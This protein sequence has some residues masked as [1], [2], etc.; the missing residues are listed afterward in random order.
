MK[1]LILML[2]L[3]LAGIGVCW[4]GAAASFGQSLPNLTG[5]WNFAQFATPSRLT[6]MTANT[7]VFGTN[8][9]TLRNIQ[10]KTNFTARLTPMTI[11]GSGNFSG[12]GTGIITVAGPGLVQAVP[13]GESGVMFSVNAAQDVA[14]AAHVTSDSGEQELML[15]LK[16]PA[17]LTTADL[18]GVWKMVTLGT[19]QN[20]GLRWTTNYLDPQH[21]MDGVFEVDGRSSFDAGAGTLTV[22]ADGSFSLV[23]GPQ[24]M[25]GTATPGASGLV[26]VTIPMP[27]PSP[28]LVIPFY[29]NQSRN[30]M[31]AV[32]T[33]ENYQEAIVA[34]KLPAA[35]TE[36]E[37]Q[38]LWR[39]GG[40][41][42]PG[43]LT[44]ITNGLGFVMDIPNRNNFAVHGEMIHIGHAGM[45]TAPSDRSVGRVSV[46]SP[47]TVQ[48]AATN[49]AGG[50][51]ST[52][53]WCN[54]G[55]DFLIAVRADESHELTLVARAPAENLAGG[56]AEFGLLLL[57]TNQPPLRVD[58]YWASGLNRVL[59]VSTNPA[60][61]ASWTDLAQTLGGHTYSPS[62]AS[63]PRAYFRVRQ[64]AP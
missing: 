20:L 58:L 33:E 53:L 27:P 6:L 15:M 18:T 41:E 45:F 43:P 36:A 3:A 54:A 39:V 64:T 62:P 8:Y 52:T 35:Q 11:D 63:L 57:K 61:P 49:D 1:T 47:G 37:S 4:Y 48:V 29:V 2:R 44:L 13:S 21:P 26:Q 60:N 5:T 22:A 38:G 16:A 17:S 23:L 51:F 42:T 7:P 30:V 14:F 25:N 12:P 59:Q 55:K 28:A 56:P 10:E 50:A 24:T 40:F 46:P 34:V 31:M 32:H 9:L 19:P